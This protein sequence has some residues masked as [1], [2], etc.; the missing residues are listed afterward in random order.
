MGNS[1]I[2]NQNHITF[3][4]YVLSLSLSNISNFMIT[5]QYLVLSN[6][7]SFLIDENSVSYYFNL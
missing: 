1:H 2:K 5:C 6:G 3:S 7:L 4:L